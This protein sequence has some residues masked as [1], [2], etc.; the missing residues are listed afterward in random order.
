MMGFV[1][2]AAIVFWGAAL[3]YVFWKALYADDA[4]AVAMW[5]A[6]GLMV[7]IA[8]IGTLFN[9]AAQQGA[10]GPCLRHATGMQYNPATRTVMPYR[11]CVER[12]GWINE[13]E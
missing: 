7:L 4:R 9:V 3:C 13:A 12:G 11:Y 10:S 1:V 2:A 6:A 8:G 5:V